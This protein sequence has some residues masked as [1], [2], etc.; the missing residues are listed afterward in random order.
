MDLDLVGQNALMPAVAAAFEPIAQDGAGLPLYRVVMRRLL[1]AIEAGAL[2]PGATLP[3]ERVLASQFQVSIGT[4]RQ[5]VGELVA[6]HILLRRQGRGTFVA[7]HTTERF[8]FQFFHVERSDG[9]REAPEVETVTLERGAADDEVAT[10][11]G[12]R[13]GE[14]VFTVEN[15]LRLQG[16]PVVLDRLSLPAVLFKGLTE[17]RLRARPSTLYRY[18]QDQFGVTVVRALERLSA[19]AADR[20]VARLLG[21]PVG[22]PML[23]VRR[24]ALSFGDKPVEYRVSSVHTAAHDYVQMLSRQA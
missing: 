13:A 22:Q 8:L 20:H 2:P 4:L 6:E 14:P 23:Q 16:R 21:V 5:A 11:L 19:V 12:M 3:S 7:H 15:R 18:Y 1:Q 9:L 10:A 24:T 17:T